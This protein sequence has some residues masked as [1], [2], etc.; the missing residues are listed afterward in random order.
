MADQNRAANG[1]GKN[2][3]RGIVI[4]ILAVI[5]LAAFISHRRGSVPVRVD[6]VTKQDLVTSISTNGKVE[7]IDNFEAHAPAA[8]TVKKIHVREGQQVHAG[9][10][11]MRLED[12]DVRAQMLYTMGDWIARIVTNSK[13]S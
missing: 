9:D 2:V 12:A 13:Q 10:L 5:V 7:P 6:K 8:T 4:A 3:R 1:N 11:L